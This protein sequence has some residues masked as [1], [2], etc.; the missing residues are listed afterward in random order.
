MDAGDTTT[1]DSSRVTEVALTDLNPFSPPTIL[2]PAGINVQDTPIP[3][4]VHNDPLDIDFCSPGGFG[5]N[6]DEVT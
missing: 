6:V 2:R 3:R 5:K 1:G 4:R